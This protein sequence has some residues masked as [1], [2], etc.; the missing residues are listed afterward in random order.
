MPTIGKSTDDPL[1]EVDLAIDPEGDLYDIDAEG[2][3]LVL[4]PAVTWTGQTASED[5]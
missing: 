3:H 2:D 5:V 1:R 4:Q